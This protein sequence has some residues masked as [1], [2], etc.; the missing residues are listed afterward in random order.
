[1]SKLR[2]EDIVD[3]SSNAEGKGYFIYFED[4]RKIWTTKR[5]TIP[6]LLI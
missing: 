4:G 3:I 5:R 6:D 1:M 2:V